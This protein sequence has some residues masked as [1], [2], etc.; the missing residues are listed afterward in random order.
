MRASYIREDAH[1][2]SKSTIS[3][4]MFTLDCGLAVLWK[5]YWQELCTSNSDFFVA[6]LA[7]SSPRAG[8]EWLL[9]EVY[10]ILQADAVKLL[11]AMDEL[12]SLA[13]SDDKARK[14]ELFE[15]MRTA[16]VHHVLVPTDLGA[17]DQ[18]MYPFQVPYA[19]RALNIC[20]AMH[21]TK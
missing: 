1:V 8:K 3:K 11:E 6:F 12:I 5:Q 18:R 7:D 9:M 17:M 15:I 21:W 14:A 16:I 13:N 20:C 10:I 2:P 19:Y 4:H